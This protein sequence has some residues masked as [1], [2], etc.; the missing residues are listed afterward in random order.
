LHPQKLE[1]TGEVWCGGLDNAEWL[2]DG[3]GLTQASEMKVY[4]VRHGHAVDG[5][6][7]LPDADRYLSAKG[8]H[9]VLQVGRALQAE[10]VELSALWTS[11]LVR[12]VQTAEILA[13]QL[14]Y[15]HVIEAVPALSPMG[16]I[17]LMAHLLSLQK[18]AVAVVGHEPSISALTALLLKRRT[19]PSLRKAQVVCVQGQRP[20]FTIEPDALKPVAY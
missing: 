3:M 7:H 19:F 13:N 2:T 4:L 5:D 8:R 20:L 12:A 18:N 14:N 15:A 1:D 17:E 16:D 9:A 6:D 11:P 10:G